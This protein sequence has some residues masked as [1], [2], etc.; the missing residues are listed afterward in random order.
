VIFSVGLIHLLADGINVLL[1][2]TDFPLGLSLCALG[3]LLA[4][5]IE[6]ASTALMS[7]I[8]T[9]CPPE[10]A[11]ADEEIAE[12]FGIDAISGNPNTSIERQLELSIRVRQLEHYHEHSHLFVADKN[13][14]KAM[15]KF[16][17]LDTSMALHSVIIGVSL[18]ALGKIIFLSSLISRTLCG[19]LYSS[20]KLT[21]SLSFGR[22]LFIK[23][24]ILRR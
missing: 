13:P 11:I 21:L 19:I 5:G 17:I 8:S 2:T 20:L 22:F 12:K 4:L 10:L 6:T 3:V 9:P 1:T 23:S 14:A 7:S 24:N 18:G 16:V 15:I